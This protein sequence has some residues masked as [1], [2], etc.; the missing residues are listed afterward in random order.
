MKT[1]T[2]HLVG[3]VLIVAVAIGATWAWAQDDGTIYYACV[4]NSSGTIKVFMEPTACNANE[5]PISWNQTGPPGPSG[6]SQAFAAHHGGA[7]LTE[8]NTPQDVLLL[9]LPQGSFI[10]NITIQ[11]QYL[12][13]SGN[14]F[15]SCMWDK[16][17]DGERSALGGWTVG[18]TVPQ[19]QQE[20]FARTFSF[21]LF[22]EDGAQVIV[23]CDASFGETGAEILLNYSNWTVIQVD[24]V[25]RQEWPTGG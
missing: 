8:S 16:I 1:K 13:T 6:T 21:E 14:G 17:V 18:G 2:L 15:V 5:L 24:T 11:S 9:D 12:A 20:T 10:S 23:F 7:L 25:H 4:N 3:L 22:D 19:G